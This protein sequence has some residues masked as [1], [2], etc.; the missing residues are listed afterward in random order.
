M[1]RHEET[2][3]IGYLLDRGLDSSGGY[4]IGYD[5]EK[6]RY[7]KKAIKTLYRF[8]AKCMRGPSIRWP[9]RPHFLLDKDRPSTKGNDT[10]SECDQLDRKLVTK[11]RAK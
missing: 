7:S 8:A 2:G 11:Q 5:L 3:I 6:R 10:S 9:I 4:F 1:N